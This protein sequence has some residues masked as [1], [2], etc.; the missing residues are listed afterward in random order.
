MKRTLGQQMDYK[1]IDY[2][3][4]TCQGMGEVPRDG[5]DVLCPTC[6]GECLIPDDTLIPV[7]FSVLRNLEHHIRELAEEPHMDLGSMMTYH[8]NAANLLATLVNEWKP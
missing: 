1:P 7:P 2:R 5:E 6:E 8:E 4:R 3:C